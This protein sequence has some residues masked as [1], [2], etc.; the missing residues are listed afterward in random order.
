MMRAIVDKLPLQHLR[1]SQATFL[2]CAVILGL[3]AVA[4]LAVGVANTPG[5]LL[6]FF[7]F[8]AFALLGILVIS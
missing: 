5:A 1:P 4:I 8:A 3:L 2:V 6:L 7:G